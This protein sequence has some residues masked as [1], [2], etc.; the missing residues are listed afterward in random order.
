MNIRGG[1]DMWSS[2]A[3][4]VFGGG[5]AIF[6]GCDSRTTKLMFGGQ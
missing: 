5:A 6:V 1:I 3:A 4:T 2:A